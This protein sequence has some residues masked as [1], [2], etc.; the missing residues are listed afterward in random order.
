MIRCCLLIRRYWLCGV[1]LWSVSLSPAAAECKRGLRGVVAV[2][3]H[4]GAIRWR[5]HTI[6]QEASVTRSR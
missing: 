4:S 1:L 3:A 6:E 5:A 2:E